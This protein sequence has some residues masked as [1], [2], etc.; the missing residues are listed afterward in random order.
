MYKLRS[1]LGITKM[2]K[3][4]NTQI[5]ELC[6]V[7]KGV[8]EIIDDLSSGV[9]QWFSYVERIKNYRIAMRPYVDGCCSGECTMKDCYGV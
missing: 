9:L 2:D 1:L 4:L 6:G 8:N 5:R 3:I 7:A